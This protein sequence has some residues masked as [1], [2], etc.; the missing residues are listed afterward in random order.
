MFD[1]SY[2]AAKFVDAEEA[3]HEHACYLAAHAHGLAMEQADE[4]DDGALKCPDCPWRKTIAEELH[5][6]C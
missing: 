6:F 5:S 1:P 2:A 3:A 4:C